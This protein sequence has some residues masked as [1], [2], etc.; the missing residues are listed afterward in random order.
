M[1]E[2]HENTSQLTIL[3]SL[4]FF[5]KG[6]TIFF[7]YYKLKKLKTQGYTWANF[8]DRNQKRFSILK[9]D[10]YFIFIFIQKLHK[11]QFSL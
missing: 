4:N 10:L 1:I 8:D 2:V 9:V 7:K 11:P 5:L 6:K 3:L